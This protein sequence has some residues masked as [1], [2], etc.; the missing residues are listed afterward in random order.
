MN[1]QIRGTA[2]GFWR[3]QAEMIQPNLCSAEG[4]CRCAEIH[5]HVSQFCDDGVKNSAATLGEGWG[6]PSGLLT[7]GSLVSQLF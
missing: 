4:S 1:L 2:A 3:R 6:R 5:L 7:H